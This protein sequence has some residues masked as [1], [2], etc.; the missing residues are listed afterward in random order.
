MSQARIGIGFFY[1]E[2]NAFNTVNTG[3]DDFYREA[4]YRGDDILPAYR[5]TRT[6]VGAFIDVL[7]ASDCLIVP[8]V[9]AAAIPSGV[10]ERGAYE[11]IVADMIDAVRSAGRL[12]GILLALHGAMVV[13]GVPGPESALLR[14]IRRTAGDEVPIATTLD[15]HANLDESIVGQT[16]IHFGFQ[17]YPHVD[18][19]EQGVRAA[20]TL[21]TSMRTGQSYTA[22]FVKLRMMPPSINMRTAEGPMH[23]VIE[24]AKGK[25]MEPGIVGVSVFGGFP[26]SD[27]PQTGASILVV[28]TDKLQGDRI[29]GEVADALWHMRHRFLVQLPTVDEG[30]A[31]ALS[32]VEDKPVVLADVSDNPLSGGSGDTTGL[33]R[34]LLDRTVDDALFG[35]LFDP[36]SLQMCQAAGEGSEIA[37]LLGGKT[38]PQFGG[39]LP[40]TARI[41]RLSDGI[42]TN[43]GPMNTGMVV[44]VKGAAHIR[45]AGTDILLTGR[46]LSANDPELFRH[47]GI[48]PMNKRILGLK[49]KNH[50]RAAF[51]PIVSRVIYVDAPGVASNR[52]DNFQ[53]V[54]IRRPMWPLDDVA[55]YS[56]CD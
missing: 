56:T 4:Y 26:Y 25:E 20:N 51:D 5:N 39:P 44:D 36:V 7:E 32:L 30:M 35:A 15:M 6:E 18:M 41:I 46:A 47:I 55:S 53:F 10:V 33:L 40:V 29:A 24:L 52:L 1:H 9:C 2:S 23:D 22:S 21:L 31:L 49:V 8:L 38:F 17:T 12:D 50:F 16:A 28:A 45:V 54:N 34:A 14:Q 42:F 11:I 27:I 48:E 37:L 13:E 43:K 19:Y 3:I